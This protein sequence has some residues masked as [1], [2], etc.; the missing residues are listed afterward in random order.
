MGH[1]DVFGAALERRVFRRLKPFQGEFAF[2]DPF[3]GG[4]P[5]ALESRWNMP[6][7][8]GGLGEAWAV[9]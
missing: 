3:Y 7:A 6:A 1:G 2:F 9:A 4:E 8:D 5:E